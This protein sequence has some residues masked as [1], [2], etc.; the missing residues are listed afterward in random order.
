[1]KFRSLKISLGTLER[2][3]HR[4]EKKE[5]CAKHHGIYAIPP[6]DMKKIYNRTDYSIEIFLLNIS[7]KTPARA[8]VVDLKTVYILGC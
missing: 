4:G 8:V 6:F 1:M 7:K 3:F 2:C 5:I